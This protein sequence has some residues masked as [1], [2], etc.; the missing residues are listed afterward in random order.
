MDIGI[1]VTVAI[2]VKVKFSSASFQVDSV[3]VIIHKA[4]YRDRF[5][6]SHRHLQQAL[7]PVASCDVQMNREIIIGS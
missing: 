2:A 3:R 5:A 6:D 1:G 7:Q 4:I